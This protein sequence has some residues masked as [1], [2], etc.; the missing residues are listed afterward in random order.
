MEKRTVILVRHGQSIMNRMHVFAGRNNT[1]LTLD[2]YKQ[3]KKTSK[4]VKKRYSSNVIFSSPLK[5]A[6]STANIIQSKFKCPIKTDDRLIETDFG[7]W[8][9]KSPNELSKTKEWEL[10]SNDP[11]HFTFPNGESPQDVKKRILDFKK[12]FLD[13]QSWESAVIVSHYTPL[14]FY[15]L[16][17]F[18]NSNCT[19]AAF[20][21][22]HG[23]ISVIE[24][25]DSIE[26]I[27]CLNFLP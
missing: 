27:R 21:L 23:G 22:T 1:E 20:K 7:K 5:R 14:V 24:Y 6:I 2:G 11:F 15:I 16:D 18:K 17:V 25:K 12:E 4:F 10:Y 19:R 26:Y 8:E 3:I 9:G 13:D